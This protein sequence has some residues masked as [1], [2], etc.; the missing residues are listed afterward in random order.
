MRRWFIPL[1]GI[2]AIACG[3]NGTESFAGP[4]STTLREGL[5]SLFIARTASAICATTG[6]GPGT[7]IQLDVTVRAAEGGWRVTMTDPAAGNLLLTLTQQGAQLTGRITGTGSLGPLSAVINDVAVTGGPG[8]DAA[9][10][11]GTIVG[12][13]SYSTSAGQTFCTENLWTLTPR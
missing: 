7:S 1:V 3:G 13:V 9:S 10:A 8:A 12:N 4:G 5:Y 11:T 2:L 6:S